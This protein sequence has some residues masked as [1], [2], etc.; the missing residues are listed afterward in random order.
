MRMWTHRGWWFGLFGLLFLSSLHWGDVTTVK[1]SWLGFPR[2]V[3][4]FVGLQLF[5]ALAFWGFSML[6]WEPEA[7]Q[8]EEAVQSS[9]DGGNL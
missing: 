2:F 6:V 1:Q 9:R 7:Q 5:L 3:L 4:W 8:A